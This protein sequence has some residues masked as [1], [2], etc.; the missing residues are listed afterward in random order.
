M[1][2]FLKNLSAL[3]NPYLMEKLKQKHSSTWVMDNRGGGRSAKLDKS[4]WRIFI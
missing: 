1:S 4:K 3:N 2:F